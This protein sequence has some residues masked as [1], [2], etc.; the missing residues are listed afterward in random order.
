MCSLEKLGIV[1]HVSGS[2]KLVIKTRKKVTTGIRVFDEKL[3]TVGRVFEI[4]GP[5]KNPYISIKPEIHEVERYIGC[6]LY[7]NEDEVKR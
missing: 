7:T 3:S 5:V 6:A 1:L 4:F 2:G